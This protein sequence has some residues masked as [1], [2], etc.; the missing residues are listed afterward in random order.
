MT[1]MAIKSFEDLEVW[2][3]SKELF[4]KIHRLAN[5]SIR[6]HCVPSVAINYNQ[7]R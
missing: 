6:Y 2:Q 7:L 1:I 4:L 3:L 5:D